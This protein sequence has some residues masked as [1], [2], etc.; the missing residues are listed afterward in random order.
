MIVCYSEVKSKLCKAN[1]P[2]LVTFIW[3]KLQ[4]VIKSHLKSRSPPPKIKLSDNQM[5]RYRVKTKVFTSYS[6]LLAQSLV[7]IAFQNIV[8]ELIS[9]YW[10][11]RRLQQRPSEN[12][13]ADQM[14]AI[15][16]VKEEVADMLS[17]IRN[18]LKANK[19]SRSRERMLRAEEIAL[20]VNMEIESLCAVFFES[21]FPWRYLCRKQ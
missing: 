7:L 19:Q 5:Y 9:R 8:R 6:S 15:L 10:A 18:I 11:R 13:S 16:A 3:G 14:A 12:A 17:E 20:E 21:S 1:L 2:R 4:S